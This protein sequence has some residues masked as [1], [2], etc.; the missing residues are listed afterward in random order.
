M[1]ELFERTLSI[2]NEL[3][4]SRR[5]TTRKASG[6]SVTSP[7]RSRIRRWCARRRP[8]R[9]AGPA[10]NARGRRPGV[11]R[12]PRGSEVKAAV[13][14]AVLLGSGRAAGAGVER[15]NAQVKATPAA[16]TP[17]RTQSEF[18]SEKERMV[19]RNVED[20]AGHGQPHGTGQDAVEASTGGDS[21]SRR[22]SPPSPRLTSA[23]TS[24]SA[25]LNSRKP[26]SAARRSRCRRRSGSRGSAL[27]ARTA[28]PRSSG[29]HRTGRSAPW[30]WRHGDHWRRDRQD[31][32]PGRRRRVVE[33]VLEVLGPKNI[34][35]Q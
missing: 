17:T 24:P 28:F 10:K 9:G 4:R 11:A 35:V 2:A 19:R 31:Q 18:A 16:A 30:K 26:G 29:A 7:R 23:Y 32:Q 6:W 34:S 15:T 20:R 25:I 8:C 14:E 27:R 13:M 5:S 3:G 12:A 21:P 1:E 22:A 33:L